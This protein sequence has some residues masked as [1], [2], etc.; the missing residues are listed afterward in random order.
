ML[1]KKRKLK[2]QNPKYPNSPIQ[3]KIKFQNPNP[4]AF[5]KFH[6]SKHPKIPD[7]LT[8]KCVSIKCVWTLDPLQNQKHAPKIIASTKL[9]PRVK[10]Q[11]NIISLQSQV[12]PVAFFWMPK[13]GCIK[14]SVCTG[15]QR[16]RFCRG[17]WW[18]D[19]L[20]RYIFFKWQS[21]VS[22]SF[23]WRKSKTIWAP[24]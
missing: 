11:N 12:P 4:K 24:H 3:I 10:I 13:E 18:G 5:T 20:G 22:C 23:T 6:K 21:T 7:S 2:F 8:Q 16:F 14:K 19:V 9:Q 17:N 1:T 15:G